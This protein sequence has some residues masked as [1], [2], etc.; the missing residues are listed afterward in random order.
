MLYLVC[1]VQTIV[2]FYSWLP[3]LHDVVLLKLEE[4][5]SSRQVPERTRK[6]ST[7]KLIIVY[8]ILVD[9]HLK[10]KDQ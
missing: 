10:N 2:V 1:Y 6:P 5:I 3:E 9:W 7:G 4:K 8:L